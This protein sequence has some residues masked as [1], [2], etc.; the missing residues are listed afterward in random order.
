MTCQ[1]I[2][3]Q[4]LRLLGNFTNSARTP[5]PTTTAATATTTATTTTTT[6]AAVATITTLATTITTAVATTALSTFHSNT[7]NDHRNSNYQDLAYSNGYNSKGISYHHHHHYHQHQRSVS[8]L[9]LQEHLQP[10]IT[11]MGHHGN[12]IHYASS[13][14]AQLPNSYAYHRESSALN[15]G[16]LLICPSNAT[17]LLICILNS[18]IVL[19]CAAQLYCVIPTKS[20]LIGRYTVVMVLL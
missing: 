16:M 8:A 18:S 15:A 14:T 9:P 4:R 7:S 19:I 17:T 13:S 20:S 12:G 1:K 10:Q 5:T 11:G 6:A 3:Q 2:L